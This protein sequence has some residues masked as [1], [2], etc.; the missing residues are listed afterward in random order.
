VKNAWTWS[1]SEASPA[2]IPTSM[3][4]NSSENF[5]TPIAT[6]TASTQRHGTP[7]PPRSTRIG[8]AA[9]V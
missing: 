5:T 4:T 7:A 3:P 1:T 8:S 6:P 2:G 9:S